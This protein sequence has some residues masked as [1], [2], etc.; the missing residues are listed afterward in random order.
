MKTHYERH[1]LSKR[2]LNMLSRERAILDI[3][4]RAVIL[5]ATMI[6]LFGIAITLFFSK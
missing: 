2:Q 3:K 4:E 6:C 1:P 5:L